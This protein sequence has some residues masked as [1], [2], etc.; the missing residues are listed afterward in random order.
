MLAANE[1]T[2]RACGFTARDARDL[3]RFG[4]VGRELAENDFLAALASPPS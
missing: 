1:D 3:E 2:F 4:I